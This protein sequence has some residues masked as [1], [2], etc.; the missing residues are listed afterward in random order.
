MLFP[1]C[2][3][4]E[5]AGVNFKMCQIFRVSLKLSKLISPGIRKELSC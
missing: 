4:S 1:D 3:F 2:M 5:L